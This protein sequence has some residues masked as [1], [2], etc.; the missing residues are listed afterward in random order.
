MQQFT[1]LKL[2]TAH[3]KTLPLV[4]IYFVFNSLAK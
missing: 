2:L 4:E 3:N 1:E